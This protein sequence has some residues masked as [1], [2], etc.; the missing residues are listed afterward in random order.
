M[1]AGEV[2]HQQM[3][4]CAGCPL[5]CDY[6]VRKKS[7]SWKAQNRTTQ[8]SHSQSPNTRMRVSCQPLISPALTRRS[9]LKLPSSHSIFTLPLLVAPQ[10]THSIALHS[11]SRYLTLSPHLF[12]LI[13]MTASVT[14]L[15]S[16][17]LLHSPF[18]HECSSLVSPPHTLSFECSWNNFAECSTPQRLPRS[19]ETQTHALPVA[20]AVSQLRALVREENDP[21]RK[22]LVV[23]RMKQLR[24][25]LSDDRRFE[26]I[27]CTGL[28]GGMANTAAPP[29]D[30]Q[31][32]DRWSLACADWCAPRMYTRVRRLPG[33]KARWPDDPD[34]LVRNVHLSVFF[35]YAESDMPFTVYRQ[36]LDR[37]GGGYAAK[38][39]SSLIR[40][41]RIHQCVISETAEDVRTQEQEEAEAKEIIA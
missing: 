17:H 39:Y 11:L 32:L 10:T 2:Y 25:I 24:P 3:L 9:C 15:L 37:E 27:V 30:S 19:D 21:V 6:R 4:R 18:V 5:R 41:R 40:D 36:L 13:S 38:M 1:A 34:E 20:D 29:V 8:E 33:W 26:S 14:P 31:L 16:S 28:R 12:A 35:L 7:G 22:E 23:S